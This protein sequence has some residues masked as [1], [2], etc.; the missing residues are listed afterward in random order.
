[1]DDLADRGAMRPAK[2]R[3][4]WDEHTAED[5]KA[6]P[7]KAGVLDYFPD[8]IYAVAQLSARAGRQHGHT[9][10]HWE[11]GKS[12]DHDDAL[13]RHLLDGDGEDTDGVLHATK[14]AW[15]ALARLQLILEKKHGLG[16]PPNA[17]D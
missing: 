9:E 14:V 2:V 7:V 3:R 5:R 11:R 4:I 13:L 17:R 10:M 6:A 15:R 1:M 16:P 8:A 12:A